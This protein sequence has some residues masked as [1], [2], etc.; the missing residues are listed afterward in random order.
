MC[1]RTVKV[2]TL[3]CVNSILFSYKSINFYSTKV[4]TSACMDFIVKAIH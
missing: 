4:C 1:V 3:V 2:Y